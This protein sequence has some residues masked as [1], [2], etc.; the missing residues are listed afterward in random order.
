MKVVVV[1]ALIAII[2]ALFS[3]L[4]FLYRDRGS[5]T[6]MV[7]ALAIRVGLSILLVAFLLIS[8]YQGWISP[9][10]MR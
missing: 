5:G 4:V 3:A 6:R 7:K 1:A 2:V 9:Q 8:Y 10:G